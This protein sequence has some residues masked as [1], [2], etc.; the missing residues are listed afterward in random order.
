MSLLFLEDGVKRSAAPLSIRERWAGHRGPKRS[1]RSAL[2]PQFKTRFGSWSMCAALFSSSLTLCL[3]A[4]ESKDEAFLR[5]AQAA[6]DQGDKDKALAFAQKAVDADPKSPRGYLF[7]GKLYDTL[8]QYEK[9]VADYDQVLKRDQ[10][11]KTIYQLRGVAHFKLAHIEQSIADFDHFIQLTPSQAAHHWQRGISYYYAGRYE[12]GR[13]QFELHQT[14]NPNDVENAVWHFLCVAR[15]DSVKKA[16]E[17][18]IP[19]ER[20]SR[21]P[22]MEIYAV[23][24]GKKSEAEVM[25]AAKANSPS[26]EELRQRLFYAHLYLGLYYEALGDNQRAKEHIVKATDEF[27]ADHYMGDVARVHSKLRWEAWLKN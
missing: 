9:A 17:S 4:A 14:V 18:L 21:V 11:A 1:R 19:I 15:S 7:R 27:P 23:F 2:P 20:D 5:Q 3:H 13:K 12:E 16:R 26:P 24:A 10:N 22:M 25:A 6:Y 8:K